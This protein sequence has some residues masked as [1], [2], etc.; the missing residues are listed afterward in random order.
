MNLAKLQTLAEIEKR[1]EAENGQKQD[2]LIV[3]EH[4]GSHGKARSPITESENGVRRPP[5]S[6]HD[7]SRRGI[8]LYRDEKR[9][10]FRER[11]ELKKKQREEDRA[12]MERNK[13][14]QE[15][16]R[17]KNNSKSSEAREVEDD[18]EQEAK[19]EEERV[20][21]VAKKIDY[22]HSFLPEPVIN[23]KVQPLINPE[24]NLPQLNSNM[25][26]IHDK[27]RAKLKR[28]QDI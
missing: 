11:Y 22:L 7:E 16:E 8:K 6:S 25:Q 13:K 4:T 12:N 17:R 5:I 28:D 1:K 23:Q 14:L 2:E 15:P 3:G 10:N 26:T 21:K 18:D 19:P 27:M 24:M 20:H 9:L